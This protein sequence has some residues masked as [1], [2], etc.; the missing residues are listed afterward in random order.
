MHKA[1]IQIHALRREEIR[2]RYCRSCNRRL[3]KRWFSGLN[4]RLHGK[5]S[6]CRA[7]PNY[8]RYRKLKSKRQ[9]H[10]T[11]WRWPAIRAYGKRCATCGESH[12]DF[13]FL[14]AMGYRSHRLK[15]KTHSRFYQRLIELAECG[16]LLSD[17]RVLCFNCDL[18]ARVPVAPIRREVIAALGSECACCGSRDERFLTVEH[19][20]QW[21]NVHR[22]I[23]GNRVYRDIL[24]G[25][26]PRGSVRL[27]CWNCN[28]ASR[29]RTSCPHKIQIS[30]AARRNVRST[31][32]RSGGPLD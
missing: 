6:S 18:A 29:D 24:D 19:V 14:K 8:G 2:R 17:V 12:I 9:Y 5:C 1:A 20:D 25:K 27:F 32:V 3:Q 22:S 31:P 7:S 30:T 13:L 21:G 11:A 16:T 4:G 26:V 23:S 10:L 28:F 15:E